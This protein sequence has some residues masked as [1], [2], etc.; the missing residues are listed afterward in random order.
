MRRRAIVLVG[1]LVGCS[2]KTSSITPADGA[3]DGGPRGS[4]AGADGASGAALV[5]VE[6]CPG[7]ADPPP[8]LE[9][10]GLYEDFATKKLSPAVRHYAPAVPLWSD[11]AVKNRWVYIPPGKT[12]DNSTPSEWVFPIGTRFWKEFSVGG[13]RIETRLFKKVQRNFWHYTTYAW[14]ADES[15]TT[16]S[17]GGDIVLGSGAPYH[18]PTHSECNDCHKGRSD[19]ILGFE[20]ALLGLPG[21]E[22]VTLD[23]LATE[24]ELSMPPAQVNLQVG[25]DGTGLAAPALA[26]MHVNCGVTC[27]N[28]NTNSFAYAA[29]MNLRLDPTL[30]DGTSLA[31]SDSLLTTVGIPA[32]TP[33]WN[34]AIRIVPGNPTGSLLV[35][36]ISH[37]G[38]GMQMPP[39]ATFVVDDADVA[40]V[41]AWVS[42]M[43]V[44]PGMAVDA[45]VDAGGG[46]IEAAVGPGADEG[47]VDATV[48]DAVAIE[49]SPVVDE[50]QLDAGFDSTVD[51]ATSTAP[52]AAVDLD[53][54][55]GDGSM[56]L[57]EAE[58]APMDDADASGAPDALE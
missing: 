6:P 10:T 13:K 15:A 37:R 30:L 9:C 29:G 20:Q 54:G 19:N 28:T 35:R 42:Q 4:D 25:D 50:T 52:E 57:G 12:I 49:A 56:V 11:G 51:D 38:M 26:W 43:P 41:V 1:L 46:A 3:G 48:D 24:G 22:G 53:G 31:G 32:K 16:T 55:L 17:V 44:Q 45:G 8:T 34:G 47:G 58:A 7:A 40:N 5:L 39:I 23:Q 33:S 21:A 2:G 18:I 14:N 36:L 27:H